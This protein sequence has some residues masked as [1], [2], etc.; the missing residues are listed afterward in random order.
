MPI[1]IERNFVFVHIPKTGGSSIESLLGLKSKKNFYNRAPLKHLVPAYKTPQHFTWL[2]L[3]QNLP[4]TFLDHAFKFTFVR[5]PWDRFVSEFIWRKQL[6]E[7]LSPAGRRN[8]FYNETDLASL[9][10]FVR[11][12]E[13]PVA[14]RTLASRGFDSHLESQ[15]SFLTDEAGKIAVDFVGRFESFIND[16]AIVARRLDV[17]VTALGHERKSDREADY[18]SYY[19]TRSRLAVEEFYRDDIRAFAYEF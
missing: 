13:L 9:D 14:E 17:Q 6:Y 18:R 8:C 1:D 7:S 19:S 10:A 2:E 12:L 5:N 16:V 15:L 11:V 4:A 3:K